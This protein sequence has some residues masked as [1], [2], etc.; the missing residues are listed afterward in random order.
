[1]Y[2][3]MNMFMKCVQVYVAILGILKAGAAYV[4]I[5]PE[6]PADRVGMSLTL[7]MRL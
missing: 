6:Y 7:F 2:L 5:D 1:M 4:P 3:P